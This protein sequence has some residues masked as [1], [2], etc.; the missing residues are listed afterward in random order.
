MH[1]CTYACTPACPSHLAWQATKAKANGSSGSSGGGGADGAAAGGAG[2]AG[3]DLKR[4]SRVRLSGLAA[5]PELNG[6][7]GLLM[8][9]V[10]AESG[11]AAVKVLA[12]PEHTGKEMKV[13][14]ANLTVV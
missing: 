9:D 1:T 4:G 12:P 5:R 2:G 3:G 7:I 10:E 13:K 14:P 8:S 11:R 6:C